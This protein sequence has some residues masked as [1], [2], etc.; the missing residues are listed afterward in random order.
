MPG[1]K[2]DVVLWKVREKDSSVSAATTPKLF[3]WIWDPNWTVTA[4][5]AGDEYIDTAT[6]LK[7][8]AQAANDSSWAEYNFM[9]S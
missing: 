4:T 6:G 3:S 9:T 5:K 7:Y 8:F 2:I 1:L